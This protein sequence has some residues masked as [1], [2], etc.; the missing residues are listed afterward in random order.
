MTTPTSPPSPRPR[1]EFRNIHV[2]QIVRYRLPLAGLVSILHRISGAI[3]FLSL[4]LVIG[5]FAYS[6]ATPDG[7][8]AIQGLLSH[9]FSKLIMLGLFWALA[10][11]LVAGLRHVW[12]DVFHAVSK[13]QGRHLAVI[14][15]VISLGATFLFLLKL[16]GVY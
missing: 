15:L 12:M 7:F 3:M 10:H 2:T 4:P 11:H 14:T 9:W 16:L 8:A 13:T 1:P 5:V 6:L